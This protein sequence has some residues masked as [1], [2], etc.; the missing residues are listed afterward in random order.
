RLLELLKAEYDVLD[1][2]VGFGER[3]TRV[4]IVFLMFLVLA[5]LFG[6]YLTRNERALVSDFRQ[7]SLYLGMFVLTVAIERGL[8]FDPWRAEVGAVLACVMVC[9]VVYNQMLAT[10][11]GFTLSLIVAVSSGADLGRFTVLMSVCATAAMLLPSVPSRS[12]LVVVGLW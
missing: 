1:A 7:L 11:T 12:T 5:L 2:G 3:A 4:A 10:L 9:A 8:S 6:C